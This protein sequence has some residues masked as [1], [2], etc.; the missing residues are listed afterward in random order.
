LFVLACSTDSSP[1]HATGDSGA[2][3]ASPIHDATMTTTPPHDARP[4][5]HDARPL[6][7]MS[8]PPPRE[9]AS[10]EAG[11]D[12]METGAAEPTDYPRFLSETG[13]FAD[14]KT[15]TLGKGVRA[16]QPKYVLWSDGAT[17]RRW[18]YLPDGGTIDTSD[19][20][21]WTYPVGTTAWKEFTRDGVRVE[22]RML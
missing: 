7:D 13:L 9:E 6:P 18:L 15:G 2:R 11:P 19:M 10:V 20:D 12:A 1:G 17:K 5:L 21:Y 16:F 3:D 4:T 14:V 22:T 8:P